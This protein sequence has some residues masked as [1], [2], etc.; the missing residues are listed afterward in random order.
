MMA[1]STTVTSYRREYRVYS[2]CR[3]ML[4]DLLIAAETEI[5]RLKRRTSNLEGSKSALIVA[6][7]SVSI[8]ALALLFHS[9]I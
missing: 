1:I 4:F 7:V 8:F 5:K 6:L 9:R 3:V 2:D